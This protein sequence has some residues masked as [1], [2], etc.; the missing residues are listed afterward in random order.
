[1]IEIDSDAA[2]KLMGQLAPQAQ[3]TNRPQ[4]DSRGAEAHVVKYDALNTRQ[5]RAARELLGWTQDRLAA[6][7]GVNLRTVQRLETCVGNPLG[8]T[9]ISVHDALVAAGI[10]FTANGK[11]GIGVWL[12]R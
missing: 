12:E 5:L 4:D 6:E 2:F 9:L 1:M 10:E 7:A 11:G 3:A 8:S